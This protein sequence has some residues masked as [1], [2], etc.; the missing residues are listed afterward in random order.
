VLNYSNTSFCV[1]ESETLQPSSL[2]SSLSSSLVLQPWL[3]LGVLKSETRLQN[4]YIFN[5]QMFQ[6][7]FSGVNLDEC[8]L[9]DTFKNHF[10]LTGQMSIL[11]WVVW[12]VEVCNWHSAVVVLFR[13]VAVNFL[14]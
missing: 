10:I 6:I 7:P 3:G 11:Q 13:T 1:H 14:L 2:S 4:F 8:F 9:K 5:L 12:L